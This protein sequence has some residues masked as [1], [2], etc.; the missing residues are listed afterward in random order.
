MGSTHRSTPT[1]LLSQ[2]VPI[3]HIYTNNK[4]HKPFARENDFSYHRSIMDSNSRNNANNQNQH[5]E[6][7][8]LRLTYY[9]Y[10]SPGAYFITIV[11]Q[12]RL[13][14][15]GNIFNNDMNHNQA[16][17]MV[18][19][20]WNEIA[21]KFPGVNPGMFVVMP[22]HF[23]G[24]LEITDDMESNQQNYPS[25]TKPYFT[26]PLI[27]QWFKTMTTNEYIRGVKFSNWPPFDR[28]L[29]QRNYYEHIIQNEKELFQ[30][31]EYIDL[32]PA[33]WSED[34]ENPDV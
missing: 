10:S 31:Y 12:N 33:Q 15:F 28:R 23:H 14:L 4:S 16:G 13:C 17:D 18:A 19:F 34:H 30:I 2:S 7:K 25:M 29:W 27:I 1:F 32:N 24:V 6:R 21:K 5:H 20:W 9:D 11:V 8:N 22:N 26:I 3:I